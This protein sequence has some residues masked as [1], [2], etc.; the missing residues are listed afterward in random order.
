MGEQ[1]TKNA[2][3]IALWDQN[4]R[5][6]SLAIAGA[7][8]TNCSK[9]IQRAAAPR[10]RKSPWVAARQRGPLRSS[11][12]GTI[13][14]GSKQKK[15]KFIYSKCR[16]SMPCCIGSVSISRCALALCSFLAVRPAPSTSGAASCRRGISEARVS[17]RGLVTQH[18]MVV[19][20]EA[21]GLIA[22]ILQ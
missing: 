3:R 4:P 9:K 11:A 7:I 1:P 21:M 12:I 22:H 8:A 17:Q 16:Q 10:M 19:L 15:H 18:V 14:S 5:M 13:G 2:L 20:G 6:Q